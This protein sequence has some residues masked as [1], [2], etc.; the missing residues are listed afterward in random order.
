VSGPLLFLLVVFSENFRGVPRLLSSIDFSLLVAPHFGTFNLPLTRGCRFYYDT[1]LI[2]DV[3]C[4]FHSNLSNV[5][6][7]R[8]PLC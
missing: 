4:S 5:F 6:I 8:F 2:S 1:R 3:L 7:V